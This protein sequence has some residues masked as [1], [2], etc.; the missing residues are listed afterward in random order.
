MKKILFGIMCLPS[1]VFADRL[2]SLNPNSQVALSTQ[3]ISGNTNYIQNQLTNPAPQTA[4]FYVTSGTVQGNLYAGSAT[5]RG[6]LSVINQSVLNVGA[7][8][9]YILAPNQVSGFYTDNFTS[10][11]TGSGGTNN[12]AVD[13]SSVYLSPGSG[14]SQLVV[15]PVSTSIT[16]PITLISFPCNGNLNGGKLTTDGAGVV[17]CADDISGSGGSSSLAISSNSVVV[18]SPTSNVNF[19]PPF[20]VN[21]QGSTTAQVTLNSSSVTLQGVFTAGTG[22]TLTPSAGA[23]SIAATGASVAIATGTYVTTGGFSGYMSNPVAVI[24]LDST[25]FI[26]QLPT[27]STLVNQ[28]TNYIDLKD[29][30]VTPGS[31]TNAT[32]TVNRKGQLTAASSGSGG[33]AST[34]LVGTGTAANF[35]T[36]ITSP[37]AAISYLG[38][39]FKSIAGGTTNFIS[40]NASSV[41]LLGQTIE[42]SEIS[43]IATNYVSFSSF[44]ANAL[45]QSSATLTYF[46]KASIY[47]ASVTGNAAIAITGT[48]NVAGGAPIFSAVSS[49]VTLLGPTID[50]SGAEITGV[51]A[52]TSFPALTGGVTTAAGALATTVALVPPNALQRGNTSYVWIDTG[53]LQSGAF[54]ISS[55]TVNTLYASTLTITPPI[56]GVGLLVNNA[57]GGLAASIDTTLTGL[58]TSF[59]VLDSTGRVVFAVQG[60]GHIVSQSTQPVLSSCGTGPS[61]AA[62]SNDFMGTVTVGSV[63]S[64]C[65]VT[66]GNSYASAPSCIVSLRT[67]SVVNALSY[68]TSTTALTLT[69]TTFGGV[70]FDYICG[71]H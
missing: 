16:G 24:V 34:L 26:S 61:L 49:S 38:D 43:D 35:T 60:S 64:G 59:Q 19:M 44:N 32:I 47:I 25:T 6:L 4:T 63:A 10:S 51:L 40:L 55:G 23:T 68:T 57:A 3:V 36:L 7:S 2:G 28:A 13:G 5:V 52:A 58:T 67:M 18:S 30:A 8:Q 46:N 41:T 62:N 14:T 15:S 42:V 69:Q 21:L 56:N 1:L 37:T 33:G 12:V 70:L 66:F 50:V 11:M 48:N 54:R 39:Q 20:N 17:T 27:I 22:I 65:T 31:Y 45:T 29:T 53:T 71:G 9:A